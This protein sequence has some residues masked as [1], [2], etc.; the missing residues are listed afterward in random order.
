MGEWSSSSN[1]EATTDNDNTIGTIMDE[2]EAINEH[3]APAVPDT[4]V[5]DKAQRVDEVVLATEAGHKGE[6]TPEKQ[7]V[8]QEKP[9]AD[10]PTISRP[11]SNRRLKRFGDDVYSDFLDLSPEAPPPEYR[12]EIPDRPQSMGVVEKSH[13]LPESLGGRYHTCDHPPSSY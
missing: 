9:S 1:S 13:L 3:P 10:N 7:G 8:V 4:Q 12:M 2:Y 6:P 11:G 5:L